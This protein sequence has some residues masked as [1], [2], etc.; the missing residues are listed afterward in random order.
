MYRSTMPTTSSVQQPKMF[1]G[2]LKEYQLKGLQWLVNCYEQVLVCTD[3]NSANICALVHG[4]KLVLLNL[5][6]LAI[7][8]CTVKHHFIPPGYNNFKS[9]IFVLLIVVRCIFIQKLIMCLYPWL[10]T[11]SASC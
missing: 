7:L 10:V 5:L 11:Y 8:R 2:L 6:V 4:F 1:L 3:T 9:L